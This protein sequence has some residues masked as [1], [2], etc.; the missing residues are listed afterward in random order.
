[1]PFYMSALPQNAAIHLLGAIHG[2]LVLTIGAG[3]IN[4]YFRRKVRLLSK[5][6]TVINIQLSGDAVIE[7][8]LIL[9]EKFSSAAVSPGSSSD[10]NILPV[11]TVGTKA[12]N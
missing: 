6:A 8:K 11:D 9:Q 4:K 3:S 10:Q 5:M 7:K 12:Q 2:G 1:M